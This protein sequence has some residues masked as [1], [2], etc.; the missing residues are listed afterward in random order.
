MGGGIF[1]HSST[2]PSIPKLRQNRLSDPRE[3]PGNFQV[4]LPCGPRGFLSLPQG[5][6]PSLIKKVPRGLWKWGLWGSLLIPFLVLLGSVMYCLVMR[7]LQ[8]QGPYILIL[9]HG[10]VT[11]TVIFFFLRQMNFN[12]K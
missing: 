1:H 3:A 7:E 12:S 4:L 8:A 5:R 11:A 9:T 2:S 10:V 6:E